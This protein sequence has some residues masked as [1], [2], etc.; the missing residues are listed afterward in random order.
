MHKKRRTRIRNKF[1]EYFSFFTRG[2][3]GGEKQT[4]SEREETESS[5]NIS[6]HGAGRLPMSPRKHGCVGSDD[7]ALNHNKE[8]KKR[9]LSKKK[10]MNTHPRSRSRPNI[11]SRLIAVHHL[12]QIFRDIPTYFHDKITYIVTVDVRG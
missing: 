11:T 10:L 2:A 6:R 9:C 8:K 12:P 3:W 1:A 5:R 4:S 7:Y